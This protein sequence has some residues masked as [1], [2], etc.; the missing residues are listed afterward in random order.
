MARAAVRGRLNWLTADVVAVVDETARV[1]S[2]VLDCPGWTG[3]LP[4]Q[5]VDIRL[6]AEDGYQAQRSYSIATPADGQR[7]TITVELVD[8]GEVSPYLIGELRVGDGVELR[9]PIGGYF[10]WEPED[11]GP[12]QLVAGGS[13][14]VPLMAMVRSRVA[15]AASDVQVRLLV[16]SRSWDDVI[17]RDEL[18]R[19]ADQQP[20][21]EIVHTLTRTQPPGWDGYA[22]RVDEAMLDESVWP[23]TDRPLCYIC[24]PTGFVESV[25]STLVKLGHEPER[26]RTE[27]FGPSGGPP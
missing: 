4:G 18:D 13:G 27:R 17:Y 1:R 23:A 2:F 25:A 24:G 20:G 12:L 6:T 10:V 26:V 7:L 5:H 14:L 19:I 15:T 21:V 8:D 9:G 11:G 16:S 22:R 3:H